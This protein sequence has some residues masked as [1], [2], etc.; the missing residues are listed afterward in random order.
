MESELRQTRPI[1]YAF[2]MFGT[3]IPINMFK[4]Y[5]AVYYV[6]KLGLSTASLSLVL[7]IYTFIDAIDN[8]I[9]G[10]FSDRTRS[11][12]GRR[13]PWLI[14]GGL[15]LGL[16]FSAF[17]NP[18]AF[19]S[20][21]SL[22][23]FFL[24]TYI[25]TGTLDSLVNTNYGA[26]FPDL[27]KGD[28]VRAK[29]NAMRQAFQLTAMIVSISL[30]PLVAEKLGYGITSIVYGILGVSVI[31]YMTF[32]CHE[33]PQNLETERP[34]LWDS[35][36][37]LFKNSKFW[38]LGLT[39]AFYS[40]ALSLVLASIPFYVKYALKDERGI[41]VTMISAAVILTAIA[42]FIVWVL[43]IKKFTLIPTWRGSL[44]TLG[45]AFI[46]LYFANSVLTAI[47]AGLLLGFGLAGVMASMDLIGARIIDED[48]VKTGIKRE[49]I[50]SSAMGVL[51]R[52]NGLFISLA[53][54]IAY[55][56]YGYESGAVPGNNPGGAAKFL[57]IIFPFFLMILSF[58]MSQFLNFKNR[59]DGADNA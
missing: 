22:F 11:K 53:F 20:T 32:G 41:A 48:S 36:K 57:L 52:L 7:L 12:W 54:F 14:I 31:L 46:P 43:A 19:V 8:P 33:N 42:S 47:L 49:A 5:A 4:T 10:Y 39:N 45:L 25:L 50:Y 58:V 56:Y 23:I 34:Q 9:Y 44:L 51:N 27:F 55:K 13:R 35:L 59:K 15:L 18:L 21:N 17:F 3:S 28:A 26:L 6:D 16:S 40:A 37:S 24:L 30:T 1:R 2:G 29:T 38:T